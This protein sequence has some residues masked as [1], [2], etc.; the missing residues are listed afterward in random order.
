MNLE[1]LANYERSKKTKFV[2]WFREKIC[3]QCCPLALGNISDFATH[4]TNNYLETFECG[5]HV[6]ASK[7]NL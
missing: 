7:Y 3:W 2:H 5:C 1:C 4:Q 6:S